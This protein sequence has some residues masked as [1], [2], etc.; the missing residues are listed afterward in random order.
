MRLRQILLAVGWA[1]IAGIVWLSLA[2]GLPSMGNDKAGHFSAYAVLMFWFAQLY[3][4]RLPWALGF[5]AMGI[6]LEFVQGW[7]GYRTFDLRDMAANTVG[8]FLGWAL[9]RLL[10]LPLAR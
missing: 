9:A 1:M 3:G 8:V 10:A 6:A 7:S 5:I 2:P 4:R